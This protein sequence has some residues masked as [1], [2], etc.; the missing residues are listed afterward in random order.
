MKKIKAIIKRPD[1]PDAY[2]TNISNT[3]PNLQKIVDGYIEVVTLA[4]DF[5][6]ICNEEGQLRG[7][8]HNFD[9]CGMEFVGTV[10][11]VGVSDEDF[12]DVPISLEEFRKLFPSV[13]S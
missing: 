1:R 12:M 3:L 2:I 5:A 13:A 7:L 8:P 6:I 4:T 11:F 10:I 9:L